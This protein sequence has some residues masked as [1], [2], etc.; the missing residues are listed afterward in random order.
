MCD[1]PVGRVVDEEVL[2]AFQRCGHRFLRINI[3]LTP[4]H[5]ANE[6]E[7]ERVC[8]S[9][10]DIVSVCPRVHQ[11]KLGKDSDSPATLGVYRPSK[12]QGLRVGKV[13]ICGG[14]GK[15]DTESG[16]EARQN[17]AS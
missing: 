10:K 17:R 5:D 9:G 3:L 16:K 1:I 4:I 12:L 13:D 8:P 6:P 2:L 15:Y 11:V 14:N 7:F